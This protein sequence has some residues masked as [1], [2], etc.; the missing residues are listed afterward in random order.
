MH[1]TMC[2]ATVTAFLAETGFTLTLEGQ[3]GHTVWRFGR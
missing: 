1:A 3:P 2:R